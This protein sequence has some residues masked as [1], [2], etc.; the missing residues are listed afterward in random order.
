MRLRLPLDP[1]LSLRRGHLG[2]HESPLIIYPSPRKDIRPSPAHR[3]SRDRG[4][5]QNHGLWWQLYGEKELPESGWEED[6]I[7]HQN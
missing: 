3:V 2:S 6:L 1:S 7:S 5:P 4:R